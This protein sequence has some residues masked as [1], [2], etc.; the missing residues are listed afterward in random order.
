M[1]I[2]VATLKQAAMGKEQMLLAF[3]GVMPHHLN[4]KQQACPACGGKDRFR[5][6]KKKDRYVCNGEGRGYQ[7]WL[8]LIAHIKFGGKIRD[9]I[10]YCS[11]ELGL[12]SL[13]AQHRESLAEKAKQA[14]ILAKKQARELAVKDKLIKDRVALKA[15]QLWFNA[16]SLLND[17]TKHSYLSRKKIPALNVRH[18]R[19]A[20][21][22]PA[23]NQFRELRNVQRIFPDGGK[24]FLKDGELNGLFSVIGKIT[25]NNN[26][27][28]IAEGYA[29]G[30][31]LHLHYQKP[32]VISFTASNLVKV[33]RAVKAIYPAMNIIIC[34]DNDMYKRSGQR[35]NVGISYARDA[36]AEYPSIRLLIPAFSYEA[37]SAKTDFN[38]LCVFGSG[39]FKYIKKNDEIIVTRESFENRI[40][41]NFTEELLYR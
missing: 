16:P 24:F 13:N 39:R 22:I 7:D 25:A 14:A 23:Y 37:C 15:Q 36:V 21:L 11:D 3:A 6:D 5:W 35:M 10:N 4:G 19:D 26:T 1:H 38:D 8:S 40:N 41:F 12:K 33:V 32:V 18:D 34:A 30:V 31:S 27:V 17:G 29:T 9:A 2:S 28:F 20:L